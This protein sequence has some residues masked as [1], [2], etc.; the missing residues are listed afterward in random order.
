MLRLKN[1]N[2]TMKSLCSP[3]ANVVI[4]MN[5]WKTC[6]HPY[7]HTWYIGSWAGSAGEPSTGTSVLTTQRKFQ[8]NN[9]HVKAHEIYIY[10]VQLYLIR[11]ISTRDLYLMYI[12][13][14]VIHLSLPLSFIPI[15]VSPLDTH[16]WHACVYAHVWYIWY[17]YICNM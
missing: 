14:N 15:H 1:N 5:I 10:I 17:K 3:I 11:T 16:M 9:R 7:R 8:R 6:I 4:V 2:K 13:T 12:Y